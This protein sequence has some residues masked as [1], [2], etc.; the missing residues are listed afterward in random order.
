M[1]HPATY[2]VLI[3]S[4]AYTWQ[5]VKQI[6]FLKPVRRLRMNRAFHPIPPYSLVVLGHEKVDT[7]EYRFLS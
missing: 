6:T 5:T 7:M 3:K 4:Y 2:P 1:A